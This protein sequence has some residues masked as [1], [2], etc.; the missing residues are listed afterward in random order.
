MQFHMVCNKNVTDFVSEV[1]RYLEMGWIL[2]GDSNCVDGEWFQ[3]LKKL[4][5]YEEK[6]VN[7]EP[8]NY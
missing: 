5:K 3:P 7:E 2:H 6:K 8:T 4:S 1:N